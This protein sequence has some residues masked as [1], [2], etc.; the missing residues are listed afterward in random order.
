MKI[1]FWQCNLTY[2]FSQ[3]AL[4]SLNAK[5]RWVHSGCLNTETGGLQTA[6]DG[7]VLSDFEIAC[8]IELFLITELTKCNVL[9]TEFAFCLRCKLPIIQR[10]DAVE[11]EKNGKFGY[12]HATCTNLKRKFELVV[13]LVEEA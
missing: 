5:E 8:N 13:D 4:I 9:G 3:K 10:S 6:P 1:F 2:S 11:S 12:I 7:Y